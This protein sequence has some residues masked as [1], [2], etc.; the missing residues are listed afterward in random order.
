MLIPVGMLQGQ[1]NVGDNFFCHLQGP[2]RT[3][4]LVHAQIPVCPIWLEPR[5][6][7]TL[8]S[9]GYSYRPLH[10]PIWDPTQTGAN[11]SISMLNRSL[12]SDDYL[13]KRQ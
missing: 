8:V 5:Q 7:Y 6:G 10:H 1:G 3:L 2:V 4:P 12:H 11:N 13:L 9:E